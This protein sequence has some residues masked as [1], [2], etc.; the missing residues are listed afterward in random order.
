MATRTSPRE[1]A[2]GHVGRPALRIEDDALLRGQGWF[3]DDLDPLPNTGCAAVVRSPFAHARIGAIDASAALALPGVIGVVTGADVAAR[4]QPFGSALGPG[5]VHYAAAVDVAR[6]VGEPVC[7]VVARDRY[8]AEDAAERVLVDY[9]PLPVAASVEAA[10]DEDAPLLHPATGSNVV[11]DRSFRYG[12]PDAAFAEAAHVIR[13]RFR[14][15]RSSATPVECYGVIAHWQN[16]GVTAWANFQ[17]PF[18]LHGV[19]AAALGIPGAK[20]R[21]LTPSESGGSFGTKAAVLHSVVLM[22]IASRC[23]GVPVRWT[24]DRNEHLLAAS[25]ATERTSVVEAAF[26][27]DG[28][29]LGLR[30]D[31]IDEVGAYVRAPEPATL[32]RMHG[33]L[34]G[35]YDVQDL[36]VRSR[37]VVSNR[38]PSGL[39]RGFGGPQL[40]SALEGTMHI[41]ARRLGIDPAELARRNLV[42][43]G[44]MPY[45]AAAGAVYDSGDYQACL[46]RALELAGYDELRA[47]QAAARAEGRL[48]GIGLAC[49][50][51]PSVSNMGYITLAQTAQERAAGLPKSGNSEGV[52]IAMGAQGG[53]TLR[54]T[55]TPQGQGHRTVAA[56]VA[57][58]VLGID[59]EQIDVRTDA[60]TTANPWTV[61]SGNY[62]SRFA[63]MGASAVHLAATRLAERLRALAA[64]LL[65]CAPED[66]ELTGGAA[67]ARGDEEYAVPIRRLAGSAHWHPSDLTGEAAEGLALTVTY[68]LPIS[69][70]DADDRVNSSA[71]YGFVAD[72]CVVEI[73]P[74]TAEVAVRTYVTV[75]DAGRLLN[76]LLADGQ[77]R[78]GLAHG[79]GAALLEEHRYDADGN[80]MTATFLDYLPPTATELPR[81]VS[82]HL[83]SP[84]PL[85]PLGAKGLGEGTT[86]S[87][88]AAIANAV[89][90]A[91]GVEHVELPAT[92][93]RIWELL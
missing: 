79:L 63:V 42:L 43:A 81:V 46:D 24:E 48:L 53:V 11:S 32:Y 33:C 76:P 52:T 82:A 41:A 16:G 72:V 35:A 57:A 27:A 44:Q 68:T 14:H 23:L 65:G 59:P 67:R 77:V 50:V 83:E 13:E 92:P 3:V 45:R 31:L 78:G 18:T 90:D 91:L 64:P 85:T 26:S 74:E 30:L 69:P 36:A 38:A 86:M 15:P 60:D 2:P 84:S 4:S 93:Q 25:M 71:C 17:G 40:Y 88:P 7:V 55:T 87:A 47:E 80:L 10:M 1:Q 62:S 37:V 51:E 8:L 9:E 75:H 5:I 56:Q 54:I 70:P 66:V 49:V 29:L 12:Q 73:D 89:A 39:N 6:Y 21:L 19:A 34:T 28:K 61:S 58:D 22:A 20:L